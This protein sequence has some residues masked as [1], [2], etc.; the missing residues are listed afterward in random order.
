M[1]FPWRGVVSVVPSHT[2]LVSS[3]MRLRLSLTVYVTLDPLY[4][5]LCLWPVWYEIVRRLR[6]KSHG[7]PR[8][9][10]CLW[11]DAVSDFSRRLCAMRRQSQA[12]AST[13]TIS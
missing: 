9:L 8:T 11:R 13:I 7:K 1:L 4:Y 10:K 12:H 2:L 6:L 5:S 3:S